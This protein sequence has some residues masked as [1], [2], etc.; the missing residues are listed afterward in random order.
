[1]RASSVY[2]LITRSKR[3]FED[4]IIK[5][6]PLR[7]RWPKSFSFLK[8]TYR[9]DRTSFSYEGLAIISILVVTESLDKKLLLN[10]PQQLNLLKI[11]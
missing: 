9:K 5:M 4:H 11:L 10:Y 1:M 3:V 7:L 8:Y 6:D 2:F